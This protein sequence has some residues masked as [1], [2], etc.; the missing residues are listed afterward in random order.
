LKFEVK[1][2]ADIVEK[3]E[4]LC[5]PAIL[6]LGLELVQLQYRREA[7]GWVVR[8]LVDRPGGVTVEECAELSRQVSSV[9]EVEDLIPYRYRLEVSSPGLD[10]PLCKREHFERFVGASI[11]LHTREPFEGRRSFRGVLR[12][13]HEDLV[14]V[15]VDLKIYELPFSAV[16]KANV[17]PVIER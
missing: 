9:L 10:R 15:E 16:D 12:G 2:L 4:Q 11:N 5:E 6:S 1:G 13:L 14:L 7:E 8:L 3:L 17:V